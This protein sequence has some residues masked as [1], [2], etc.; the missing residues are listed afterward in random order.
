MNAKDGRIRIRWMKLQRRK[1]EI[2]MTQET[3]SRSLPKNLAS[4]THRQG[5]FFSHGLELMHAK[6]CRLLRM[7]YE[8]REARMPE[9]KEAPSSIGLRGFQKEQRLAPSHCKVGIQDKTESKYGFAVVL[10]TSTPSGLTQEACCGILK[11]EHSRETTK[12]TDP[13]SLSTIAKEPLSVWL[14][15]KATTL[16]MWTRGLRRRKESANRMECR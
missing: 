2:T 15:S 13:T 7:P 16:T 9:E 14:K 10:N 1:S 6:A 8:R 4:H 12:P 3:G 5:G 11:S